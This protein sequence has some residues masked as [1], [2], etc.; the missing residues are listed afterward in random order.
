MA[1]FGARLAAALPA[2]PLKSWSGVPCPSCGTTR[3]ALALSEL[4]LRAALAVS[5]LATLAWMAL[6]G[7]GLVAGVLAAVGPG[8]PQ[9]NWRPTVAVRFGIVFVILANWVYLIARGI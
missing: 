1:P 4:D 8:L 2:C 5:P 3:A 9:P 7:G 6:I